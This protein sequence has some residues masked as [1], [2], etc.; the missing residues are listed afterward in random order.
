LMIILSNTWPWP[1]SVLKFNKLTT[2]I[3]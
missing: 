2:I 3:T 1:L